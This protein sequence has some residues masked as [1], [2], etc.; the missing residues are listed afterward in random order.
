ML[1][2]K[3]NKKVKKKENTLSTKKN[4]LNQGS[5]IQDKTITIKKKDEGSGKRKLE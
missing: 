5:K 2:L 1:Q 3:E 4:V